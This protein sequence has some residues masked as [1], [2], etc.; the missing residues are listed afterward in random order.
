MSEN[1]EIQVITGTKS[2]LQP[3]SD[4]PVTDPASGKVYII[5][6]IYYYYFILK[7]KHFLFLLYLVALYLKLT[8]YYN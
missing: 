6:I 7:K 5:I 8:Y 1:I 3:A 4:C 2:N